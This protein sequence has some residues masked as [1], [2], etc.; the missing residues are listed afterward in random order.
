MKKRTFDTLLLAVAILATAPWAL[1]ARAPPLWATVPDAPPLPKPDRSGFVT[2]GGARIYYAVFH[3][4]GG[5]PVILLHG[6][7]SSSDSWGFEVPR[8]SGTHEVIVMDSRGQG[9][10]SGPIEPLS[11]ELM[12]SDVIALM[13]GVHVRRASI[14]GVSDGGII[15]LLLAIHHPER[16]DRLFAWARTSIPTQA[17]LSRPNR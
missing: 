15:G 17:D 16:V 7:F 14:V 12:A 3:P 13:D 1:A 10:S 2:N 5:R 6:G 4:G 8:L 9:R 11:Y